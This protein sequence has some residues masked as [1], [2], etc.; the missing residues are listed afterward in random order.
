MTPQ[1]TAA[2]YRIVPFDHQ[3]SFE[4]TGR[5]DNVLT[6][7]I[8]VSV[9]GHFIAAAMGYGLKP[10]SPNFFAPQVSPSPPGGPPSRLVPLEEVTLG[11]LLD[12]YEFALRT[13]GVAE[14]NLEAQQQQMLTS[15]AQIN[16]AFA[17]LIISQGRAQFPVDSLGE[18]INRLFQTPA[19]GSEQVHFLYRIIDNASSRE[20]QSEPVHN[21]AGLGRANGDRPFRFF[22]RP[23]IFEPRAVIRFQITEI[24]G[25]GRLYIVLQGYKVLRTAPLARE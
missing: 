1:T 4:L 18:G 20:L 17:D 19:C 3:V 23:L 25:R 11:Q 6:N 10:V 2:E 9:E 22:P 21:L 8:S 14:A 5:R 7:F 16:P 24:S 12:G 15:G 13:Q